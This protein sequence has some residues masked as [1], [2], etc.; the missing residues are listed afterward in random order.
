MRT[1]LTIDEAKAA[2]AARLAALDTEAAAKLAALVEGIPFL[3]ETLRMTPP[4]AKGRQH[5]VFHP[6]A[7]TLATLEAQS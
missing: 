2:A 4:D 7:V 5:L 3:M 6:D 1:Q